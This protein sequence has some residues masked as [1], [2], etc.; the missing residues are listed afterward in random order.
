[1]LVIIGWDVLVEAVYELG[2]DLYMID[3]NNV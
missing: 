3:L 1:M 2:M